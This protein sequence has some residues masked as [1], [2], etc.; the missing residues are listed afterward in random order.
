[1]LGTILVY[2]RSDGGKRVENGLGSFLHR[3][4]DLQEL[5]DRIT[6]CVWFGLLEIIQGAPQTTL[7]NE[8]ERGAT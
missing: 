1:M 2:V 4:M 7:A 5:L 8:F 3:F 6:E